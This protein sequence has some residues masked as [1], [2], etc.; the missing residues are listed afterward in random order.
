MELNRER[1]SWGERKRE[2]HKVERTKEKAR[3]K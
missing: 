1:N 2:K 3:E